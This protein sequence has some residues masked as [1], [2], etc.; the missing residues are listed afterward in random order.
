MILYPLEE[1]L[2]LLLLNIQS[3]NT[4]ALQGCT[5]YSRASDLGVTRSWDEVS[6]KAVLLLFYLGFGMVS[7]TAILL[8]PWTQ[9]LLLLPR[10]PLSNAAN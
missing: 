9:T 8:R 6:E 4:L 5:H 1:D 2:K 10:E 3:M 7:R